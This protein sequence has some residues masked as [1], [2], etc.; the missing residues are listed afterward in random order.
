MRLLLAALLGFGLAVTARAHRLDE[1]LQATR[2]G[3]ERT[4]ITLSLD[5][6]P[7]AEIA[8]TFRKQLKPDAHGRIAESQ[9]RSFAR[10]VVRDLTLELDGKRQQIRL[11]AV[12]VPTWEEIEQGEGTIR[13]R[14]AVELSKVAEGTHEI[15]YC[16]AHQPKISVYLV[17]ALVPSDRG[18][19]IRRQTRDAQQREYRVTFSIAREV[20]FKA[21]GP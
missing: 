2:I 14:A 10:K 7:G 9:A 19:E 5:L 3:I 18:T 12:E 20:N 21:V 6:T 15:H 16:N 1:Y 8:S 4:Q 13:V 17:N 11:A